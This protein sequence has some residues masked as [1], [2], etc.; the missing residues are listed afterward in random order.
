MHASAQIVSSSWS[1]QPSTGCFRGEDDRHTAASRVTKLVIA[2]TDQLPLGRSNRTI[3]LATPALSG[4]ATPRPLL[5]GF[6]GQGSSGSDFAAAHSYERKA[7]AAGYFM[8]HPWGIDTVQ[9]AGRDTGWNV[10]TAGDDSTCLPGTT[11]NSTHASCSALGLGGRCNWATCYDDVAFVQQ[12]LR[13][14]EAR[15]CLDNSRYPN[16]NP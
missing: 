12:L 3:R 8:V 5:L 6:H 10:G 13:T 14:L 16:P 15:Y 1:M 7:L 4:A 2:M 11:G 9:D